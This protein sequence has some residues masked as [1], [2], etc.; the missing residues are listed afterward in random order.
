VTTDTIAPGQLA[1]LDQAVSAYREACRAFAY[2][3]G[4]GLQVRAAEAELRRIGHDEVTGLVTL[5]IA[6]A[7]FTDVRADGARMAAVCG[8]LL[9]G[10]FSVCWSGRCLRFGVEDQTCDAWDL[11]QVRA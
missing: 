2:G 1:A 6:A 7:H 9:G 8:S 11:I 4:T 5:P 10:E 3:I